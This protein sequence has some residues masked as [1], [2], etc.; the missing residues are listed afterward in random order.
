MATAAYLKPRTPRSDW[1]WE[2]RSETEGEG[3]GMCL[4]GIGGRDFKDGDVEGGQLADGNVPEPFPVELRVGGHSLRGEGR[5]DAATF[6]I[7]AGGVSGGAGGAISW[8]ADGFDGGIGGLGGGGVRASRAR[9][10]EPRTGGR[11]KRC[12]GLEFT[13]VF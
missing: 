5:G 7:R 3:G 6:V 4:G 13:D 8:S 10:G 12:E 2:S 1:M 9:E 11:V